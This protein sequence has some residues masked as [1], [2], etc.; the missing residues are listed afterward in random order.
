MRNTTD[1]VH[2]LGATGRIGQA[3]CR[4]LVAQGVKVIPLVHEPHRWDETGIEGKPRAIDLLDDY[5]MRSELADAV[6]VIS[7]ASPLHTANILVAT[8]P[9]VLL[10]LLGDARR[11]LHAPDL[12]GLTAMEGEREL[13]GS[14]RPAAMLHPTLIYGLPQND[15]VRRW[16]SWMRHLPVMPLPAGGRSL[17]Q[18]IALD[19]VVA[20]ILAATDRNWSQPAVVP[21][22]G[23]QTVEV[24]MFLRMIAEASGIAMPRVF[25]LPP[26]LM[27]LFGAF[28][29]LIPGMR[30]ASSD[31]LRNLSENRVVDVGPMRDELGIE[32]RSLEQG[33][34][35]MFAPA[36]V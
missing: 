4:A 34:R 15:P 7:C 21:V 16:A 35:E 3:V 28:T 31:D 12:A 25:S 29:A 11:Y 9:D 19:D 10:V 2:V 8:D 22:G 27:P 14:G 18:P 17:I 1:P 24:A 5:S 26:R 30:L 36:Q 23:A 33:L 32:A 13:I 20:C 6:R